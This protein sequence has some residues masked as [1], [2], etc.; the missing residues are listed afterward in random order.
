M[1]ILYTFRTALDEDGTQ[2]GSEGRANLC[3]FFTDLTD[4]LFHE[5]T[6]WVAGV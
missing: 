1:S 5:F 3:T 4:D 6:R 2:I